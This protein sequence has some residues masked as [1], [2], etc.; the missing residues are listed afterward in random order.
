[1]TALYGLTHFFS[2]GMDMED[3]PL[4]MQV[5]D[6]QVKC[7][8]TVLLRVCECHTDSVKTAAGS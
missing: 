7:M 6:L 4:S 3:K 1:L 5:S 8:H 2:P